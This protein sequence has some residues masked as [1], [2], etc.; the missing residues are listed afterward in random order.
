MPTDKRSHH[1][2]SKER[3]LTENRDHHRKPQLDKTKRSV[4][5][6]DPCPSGFIYITAPASMAVMN[7]MEKGAEGL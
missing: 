5:Y 3:L 6:R 4:D 7:I 1:S 2:L